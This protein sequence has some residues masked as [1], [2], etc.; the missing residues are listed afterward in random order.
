YR[1][2]YPPLVNDARLLALVEKSCRRVV[3]S[4]HTLR[5]HLPAMGSEDFAYFAQVL[6]AAHFDLGVGK[7]R[8]TNYPWHHPCFDL[9]EEALPIGASLFAQICWDYLSNPP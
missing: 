3:G 8:A 1:E 9:D 7:A 5:V 2:A 4:E 6:P